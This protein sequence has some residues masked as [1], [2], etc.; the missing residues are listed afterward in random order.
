MQALDKHFE[1]KHHPLVYTHRFWKISRQPN[2]TIQDLS[3][4]IREAAAHCKFGKNEEESTDIWMTHLLLLC[5]SSDERQ[6]I[7]DKGSQFEK[8]FEISFEIPILMYFV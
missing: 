5:V 2:E 6:K 8:S 7:L 3:L 1:Q 4:R